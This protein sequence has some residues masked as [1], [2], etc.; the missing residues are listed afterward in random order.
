MRGRVYC[1]RLLGLL[2]LAAALGASRARASGDLR[3]ERLEI[4]EGAELDTLLAGDF[5]LISVLVDTLGDSD[6][7]NDSLRNV[8]VLTYTRPTIIQRIVAGLP[9]VYV[10]AG[11][12]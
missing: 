8:W 4:P 10:R 11:S 7:T 12:P 5:P 9:F 1:P 3:V 2:V 6:P